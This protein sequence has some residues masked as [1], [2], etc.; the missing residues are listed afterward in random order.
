[1]SRTSCVVAPQWMNSAASGS[2]ARARQR[3]SGMIGWR[4]SS[5]SRFISPRSSSSTRAFR[6]DLGGGRVGNDPEPRLGAGE[7]GLDVEPALDHR[8]IAP[9]LPHLG[10]RVEISEERAVDHSG[11]RVSR[12]QT[13]ETGSPRSCA[14]PAEVALQRLARQLSRSEAEGERERQHRAAERDPEDEQDH[15]ARDPELGQGDGGGDGEDQP[16]HG[17]RQEGG[18][19]DLRVDRGDQHGLGQ[20]LREHPARRRRRAP[21]RS[22]AAGTRA[23]RRPRPGSRAS[24]APRPP[25]AGPTRKMAQYTRRPSSSVGD[26]RWPARPRTPVR[27]H[28]A[29]RTSRSAAARTRTVM[30]RTRAATIQ[31]SRISV[32]AA[33]SR[34]RDEAGCGAPRP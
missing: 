18:A 15:L 12:R 1:M 6:V 3:I 26:G 14:R 20:E 25:S 34:G 23:P 9:H 16:A 30:R 27:P 4:A 24:P 5:S 19:R 32:S 10:G 31:P 7:R 8:A 22:R 11:H 21:R 2:Q 13:C 33:R 28:R 17:R 29:Q